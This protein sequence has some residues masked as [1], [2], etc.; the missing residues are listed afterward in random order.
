[1]AI[2]LEQAKNLRHGQTLYGSTYNRKGQPHQWRVNG[3]VKT[4]KRDPS[5]VR[6][7]IKHGLY[8]YDYI[9]EHDLDCVFLT[10]QEA[11]DARG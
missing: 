10:E 8:A 11:L 5:R 7:P 4:W 3:Q 1:M 9:T 6:V 2:T